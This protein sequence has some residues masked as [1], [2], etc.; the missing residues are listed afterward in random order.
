LLEQMLDDVRAL[1]GISLQA[2]ARDDQP[3]IL[4]F[5]D[6][7]GF[8]E[9]HRMV[10][11]SLALAEVDPAPLEPLIE[12]VTG[13]GIWITTLAEEQERRPDYLCALTDAHNAA[14]PGWPD[15]DPD[16]VPALPSPWSYGRFAQSLDELRP[17]PEAFFIACRGEEYLGYSG[18]GVNEKAAGG[19]LSAGTA[20]RAD[21]RGQGVATALKIRTVQYACQHGYEEIRTTTANPAMRFV[22]E[23]IGFR[24]GTAE[25]RLVRRLADK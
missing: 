12:R 4:S 23:K 11:L 20:V 14:L 1:G 13:R 21:A 9:T 17:I 6:R 3:V 8:R 7:R 10:S 15:P 25:V 22:N 19:L 5:L 2:R 16:P 18:L 24:A